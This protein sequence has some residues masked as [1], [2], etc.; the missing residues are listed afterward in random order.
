MNRLQ[1]NKIGRHIPQ[2]NGSVSYRPIP[3]HNLSINSVMH[4]HSKFLQK[5]QTT[6]ARAAVI[7][8]PMLLMERHHLL[9]D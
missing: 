9:K 5:E 2:E 8:L 7:M 1:N 3:A 4:L 6:A